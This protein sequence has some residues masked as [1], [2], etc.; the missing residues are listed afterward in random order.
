M[1]QITKRTVDALKPGT[2]AWDEELAGFGIRCQ[3]KAKSY[4]L[5][6]RFRGKQRWLTIGKH[7]AP[8]TPIKARDRARSLLG[9]VADGIDPAE[10]RDSLKDRPSGAIV[11]NK[12]NFGSLYSKY[13]LAIFFYG[14]F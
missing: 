4:V 9:M 12:W 1:T 14:V 13:A 2:I 5:K 7:G 6:Y 3:E 10:V 11:K 8:W